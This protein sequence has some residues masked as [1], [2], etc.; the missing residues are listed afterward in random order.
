MRYF[1]SAI[2][3]LT[4]CNSNDTAATNKDNLPNTIIDSGGMRNNLMQNNVP[5]NTTSA[6]NLP[7]QVI[8]QQAAGQPVQQVATAAGGITYTNNK[9]QTITQAEY[10][11]L[12][13]QQPAAQP[14]SAKNLNPAHGQPGHRCDIAVGAPLNSKPAA[15]TT[16]QKTTQPITTVT[17]TTTTAAAVAPGT[18]PAHG[19]PGHRCDIGVGQPLNSKPAV[20]TPAVDTVIKQ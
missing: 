4:A 16:A 15:A 6:A 20:T 3:V 5:I 12:M 17:P 14:V 18:N 11:K 10:D 8:P 1:L 7:K 9:G 2:I 19:Q 13:A